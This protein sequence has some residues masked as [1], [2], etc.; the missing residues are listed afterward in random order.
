MRNLLLRTAMV[1]AVVSSA[2]L[3][4]QGTAM[5]TGASRVRHAGHRGLRRP[6]R[7]RVAQMVPSGEGVRTVAWSRGRRLVTELLLAVNCPHAT[8]A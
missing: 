2:V 4:L 3:A 1:G 8:T 6:T 5:A 7:R